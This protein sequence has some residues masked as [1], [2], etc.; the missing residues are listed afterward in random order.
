VTARLALGYVRVST[1]KQAEAG[2]SLEAQSAKIRAMAVV[3]GTDVADVIIDA[4]ESAK[5]LDRPGMTWLLA[6]VDAGEVHTVIIA[7]LDRLTRSVADLADLLQRFERR[8]VA[9]ISVA[10]QLDTSSAVGRLMLNIMVSVSQWEREA[11]GERTRDVMRHKKAKGERVGTLP[12]GFQVVAGTKGQL[13]PNPAEQ[14]KLA[15][16][17]ALRA[18]GRSLRRVA[19]DATAEGLTNRRGT[20]FRFQSV[21]RA[22]R[23]G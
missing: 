16:L 17:Q 8:R 19:D 11:I 14:H 4:G 1:D 18:T 2:L 10:E 5:S 12:F 13:E 23:R 20:P 15:R 3:R 9:L 7:K 21:A 6:Q 22:L